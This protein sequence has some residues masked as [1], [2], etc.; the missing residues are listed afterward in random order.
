M[1]IEERSGRPAAA[2]SSE[3]TETRREQLLRLGVATLH[4]AAGKI[5]CLPPAIQCMTPRLHLAGPSVTVSGPPGDNLWLHRAVYEAAPGDILL[6]VVGGVYEAGYWGEVLSWAAKMRGLGGVVVDGCVRDYD[7]LADI[8]VPVFGRGLCMRGTSKR[9]DGVGSINDGITV[10]DVDVQP[11]DYI[12]GDADGVVA[13]P[14]ARLDEV[15]ALALEREA[16]ETKAIAALQ[17]GATTLDIYGLPARAA[18]DG[19]AA[20]SA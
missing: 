1:A 16:Y 11:G 12:V 4:E 13:L 17:R 14:A 2:G 15:I 9:A 5:G 19:R 18:S 8:G 7:R 20:G 6:A 10:G 3:T